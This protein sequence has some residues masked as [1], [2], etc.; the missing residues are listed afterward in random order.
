MK[1]KSETYA[2]TRSDDPHVFQT[3][4]E[5]MKMA[6]DL[7]RTQGK[8]LAIWKRISVVKRKDNIEVIDG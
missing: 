4:A 1:K 6:S 7:V 5:A 3:K 8:P 2:I